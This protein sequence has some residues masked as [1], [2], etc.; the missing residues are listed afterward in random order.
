MA[1][2]GCVEGV[3]ETAFHLLDE[4]EVVFDVEV[5]W[6]VDLAFVDRVDEQLA[7]VG[8]VQDALAHEVK[9]LG[10][11]EEDDLAD[12]LQHLAHLRGPVHFTCGVDGDGLW[13]EL[14]A[15]LV[16]DGFRFLRILRL[17]GEYQFRGV[18]AIDPLRDGD[19]EGV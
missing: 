18:A 17:E 15:E 14:R 3:V 9:A 6:Q 8:L 4:A 13:L 12:A 7:E 19:A 16:E 5:V 2:G 10:A 1:A 11:F